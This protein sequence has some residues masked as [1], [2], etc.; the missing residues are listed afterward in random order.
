MS[1]LNLMRD[2]TPHAVTWLVATA[3]ADDILVRA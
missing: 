3:F 1:I 2:V